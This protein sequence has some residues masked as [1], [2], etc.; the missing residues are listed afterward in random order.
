KETYGSLTEIL[1]KTEGDM[2]TVELDEYIANRQEYVDRLQEAGI[3]L[4]T[5]PQTGECIER[6]G[7]LAGSGIIKAIKTGKIK[8]GQ[9]VICSLSGG[10]GPLPECAPQPEWMIPKNDNL[11]SELSRYLAGRLAV[12]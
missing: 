2:L 4:T 9:T 3:R 8:E 11:E 10:T 6:A 12:G 7:V 5:Q 1:F